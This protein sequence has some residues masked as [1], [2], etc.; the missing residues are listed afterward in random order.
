MA[1][2]TKEIAKKDAQKLYD[3]LENLR[4]DLV[5]TTGDNYVASAEPELRERMGELYANVASSYDRVSGA[6]KQNYKLISEEFEKEKLRF[7]EI[8][9]KEGKKFTSFLEKNNLEK[10]VIL[11]KAEYLDK[12]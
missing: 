11:S 7:N 3:A 1:D 9:G 10:P 5:I 8:M 6:Q 4:K 12:K 2:I